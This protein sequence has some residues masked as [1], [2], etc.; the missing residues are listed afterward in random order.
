MYLNPIEPNRLKV[1]WQSSGSDRTKYVVGELVR[2]G[3]RVSLSYFQN[4]EQFL[5]AFAAGFRG[6]PAFPMR[7]PCYHENVL[8]ILSRRLPSRQRNDFYLYLIRHNINPDV[9]ISDFALLGYTNG[10]LP[11][12][13]FSFVIDFRFQELPLVFPIEISGFRYH[14][15]MSIPTE[16]LLKQHV[17]FH[18]DNNN[19]HDP[20][21]ISILSD[22]VVLGY[23]PRYYAEDI[24]AWLHW[25]TLSG[26]VDR[27]EGPAKKPE[28]HVMLHVHKSSA[29]PSDVALPHHSWFDD[30]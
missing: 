3:E 22:G 2:A 21:A 23:V 10:K 7:N 4:S 12:D 25:I 5:R 29:M 19:P 27:I 20:Y 6:H 30:H 28:V 15:G 26:F 11:S 17:S 18:L 8:E 14:G 1:I 13:G 9:K 24:R 16:I